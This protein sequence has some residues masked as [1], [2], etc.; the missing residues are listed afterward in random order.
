LAG[1][2]YGY[3]TDPKSRNMLNYGLTAASLIPGVPALG[4]I[5]DVTKK[6]DDYRGLHTAPTR[7]GGAPLHEVNRD[8]YPDDIYG[9]NAAQYYGHGEP[10]DWDSVSVIHAA[11]GK[12]DAKVTIYRAVPSVAAERAKIIKQ[13]DAYNKRRIVPKEFGGSRTEIGD[14]QGFHDWATSELKRLESAT[15]VPNELNAGDWVTTSRA[16]AQQHGRSTL[17]G[18]YKIIKKEVRAKDIYTDGNSIHE[19]G[20]DPE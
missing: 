20:Y 3:A 18:N 6:A 10:F 11:K 8:V 2:A 4:K 12:P 16:Y 14:E 5:G 13:L 19:W 9:P 1:D 15:D 7:K 17:G